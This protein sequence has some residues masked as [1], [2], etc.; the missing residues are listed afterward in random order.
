[1]IYR[2]IYLPLIHRALYCFPQNTP[3]RSTV[4]LTPCDYFLWG[5]LKDK[6][7]ATPPHD[8][9]ALRQRIIEEFDALRQQPAL[10]S[11]AVRDMHRRTILCV[12]RNG[13]HV[14]GRG[15]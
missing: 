8:I 2:F 15:A 5:Y 12:E 6:I 11:R 4:T 1:M 9:D 14:E 13:D 3:R 7:F 10:I